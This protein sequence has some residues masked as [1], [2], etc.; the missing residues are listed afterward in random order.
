M[1]NCIVWTL[2]YLRFFF[3]FFFL[4]SMWLKANRYCFNMKLLGWID[5]DYKMEQKWGKQIQILV[6]A[7]SGFSSWNKL[8]EE[9]GRCSAFLTICPLG[10]KTLGH[11]YIKGWY[12]P[13][14]PASRGWLHICNT[15][16]QELERER[17]GQA[18]ALALQGVLVRAKRL[19]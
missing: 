12:L 13:L 16:G 17:A 9:V 5:P 11:I 2:K 1:Y 7:F 6:L 3:F 8:P 18:A 14:T 4:V 15:P 10:L 19:G